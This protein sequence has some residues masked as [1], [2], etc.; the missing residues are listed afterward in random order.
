MRNGDARKH[1]GKF[2]P[3]ELQ[4]FAVDFIRRNRDGPFLLLPDVPDAR[5]ELHEHVVPRRSTAIDTG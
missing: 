2:G 1:P 5:K 4:T 3:D